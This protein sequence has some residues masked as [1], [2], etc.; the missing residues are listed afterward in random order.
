VEAHITT[1]AQ[2]VVSMAFPDQLARIRK[3]KGF[4]QRELAD[5]VELHQSQIHRY[6]SAT[7]Q[8]TLDAI[9][10]LAIAL[11]VTADELVFEDCE[12]GPDEDLRLQFEAVSRFNAE[13]KRTVRELLDS[14]ILKHEARRWA[15]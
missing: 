1:H 14:L 7:S 13:E 4:T 8:P 11:G 6:E 5:K 2:R 10:R 3:A 15:G 12:R 9:R